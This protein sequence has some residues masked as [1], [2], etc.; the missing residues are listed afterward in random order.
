MSKE[1]REGERA[2]EKGLKVQY[3][4]KETNKYRLRDLFEEARRLG[5]KLTNDEAKKYLI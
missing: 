1:I 3:P 5:R 4:S 2:F